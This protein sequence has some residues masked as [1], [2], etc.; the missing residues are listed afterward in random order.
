MKR[1]TMQQDEIEELES[2]ALI[3]R[4][5]YFVMCPAIKGQI[6]AV[7]VF[8]AGRTFT[9]TWITDEGASSMDVDGYQIRFSEEAV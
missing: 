7:H 4:Q 1:D 3:G 2:L 6:T 9:V 5:V 8:R